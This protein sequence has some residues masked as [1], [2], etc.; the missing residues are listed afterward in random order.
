MK[1]DY[2]IENHVLWPLTEND[3]APLVVI[4]LLP[5][6][7]GKILIIE[8]QLLMKRVELIRTAF[9]WSENA[10]AAWCHCADSASDDSS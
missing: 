10:V 3:S 2:S 1:F 6:T 4:V 9:H 5:C 7:V 8:L